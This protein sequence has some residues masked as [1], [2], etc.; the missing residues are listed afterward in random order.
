M[1]VDDCFIA[2]NYKKIVARIAALP[3]AQAKI[4]FCTTMTSVETCKD[5]PHLVCVTTSDGREQCFDD[6][7]VTTPLGW[8]KQH[9]ES[10]PQL[11]PRI[12][13]AIESISFGRLEKV[14]HIQPRGA[15]SL[16]SNQGAHRI[17]DCLLG[18]CR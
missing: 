18:A 17:P 13:S 5:R 11:H 8:L 9:M 14:R 16:M 3:L 7:V 4:Q 15:V 12:V 6:V 10:I 2:T 1:T